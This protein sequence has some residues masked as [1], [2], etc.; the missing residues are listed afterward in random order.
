MRV[1]YNSFHG[2]FSDNPRALYERLRDLP[3]T[4]HVWL[5]DPAHAAAFPDDV[6]TVRIDG[7][8]ARAALESADLVVACTHTEIEWRK[9]HGA[10]YLQTWHGTPL[11]R[12]H[13][14][15]LWAPPGRLDWLDRDI[16]RWDVLLSPNP[17]S[18]LRLRRAF[19]FDKEVWETG[20][21]RNDILSSPDAGAVRVDVRR[22]LGV[23]EDATVVLYAPTWRDDEGYGRLPSVPMRLDLPALVSRLEEGG[24]PHTVIARVHNLMTGRL[25]TPMGPGVVDVSWHPDV[26][27]LYLA[28]DVLVTDYSSVMFDFALTGKPMVFYAYDLARYRDEVRGF[29]FD[30]LPDAPGPVVGDL[31]A[32]A[33]AV[34]AVDADRERYAAR[35]QRF[36]STYGILEDGHATD[37][38]LECLGLL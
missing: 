30:L 17:V 3:G 22:A 18:S 7:P 21:P 6:E 23:P 29:Y 20:Y 8:Q 10:R 2:R 9:R 11:K 16:A 32:L 37:R 4:E 19:G 27:D 28:A 15:V 12:V 25:Q 31:D 13:R 35:Y 34:L 36:R 26:R 33:E 5:L 24:R 38:V 1:V 14:D